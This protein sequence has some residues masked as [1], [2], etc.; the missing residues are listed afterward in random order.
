MKLPK[1]ITVTL[2]FCHQTIQWA[3]VCS[4]EKTLSTAKIPGVKMT[5]TPLGLV[6][7]AKSKQG[8]PSATIVPLA[9]IANM[10]IEASEI[11]D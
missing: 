6:L 11:E 7:Q 3:G 10:V 8:I 4:S 1:E 5:L 9:N 2:A